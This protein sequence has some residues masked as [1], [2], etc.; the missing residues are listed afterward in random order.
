MNKEIILP[1]E[2]GSKI[3]SRSGLMECVRLGADEW[4]IWFEQYD[5]TG[6]EFVGTDEE[7]KE[8]IVIS[9]NFG[10][11][12]ITNIWKDKLRYQAGLIRDL[13]NNFLLGAVDAGSFRN[14]IKRLASLIKP[15]TCSC[16]KCLGMSDP[17][18]DEAPETVDSSKGAEVVEKQKG[19]KV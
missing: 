7:V 9:Q 2:I 14:E 5:G 12:P 17:Y 15:N 1:S 3:G 4:N 8:D 18:A 16:W 13:A 19:G 11:D 6:M 10:Y